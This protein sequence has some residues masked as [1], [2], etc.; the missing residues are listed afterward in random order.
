ML[1]KHM[2]KLCEL[3]SKLIQMMVKLGNHVLGKGEGFEETAFATNMRNEISNHTR[4]CNQQLRRTYGSFRNMAFG[5]RDLDFVDQG[6]SLPSKQD[7][8]SAIEQFSKENKRLEKERQEEI[9]NRLKRKRES[10]ERE[11]KKAEERQER[12]E[13]LENFIFRLPTI[14]L[15]HARQILAATMGYSNK[16]FDRFTKDGLEN[17]AKVE[18]EGGLSSNEMRHVLQKLGYPKDWLMFQSKLELQEVCTVNGIA[19][20]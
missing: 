8:R 11:E 4:I 18:L 16:Y 7:N 3:N 9:E 19:V 10:K 5:E 13:R 2:Y 20:K 17:F 1:A 6:N 14:S 12:K 15:V